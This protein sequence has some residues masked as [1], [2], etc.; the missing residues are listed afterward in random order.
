MSYRRGMSNSIQRG[1]GLAAG[2]ALFS[3]VVGAISGVTVGLWAATSKLGPVSRGIIH[4]LLLAVLV[5][6]IL[7]LVSEL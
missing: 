6:G 7:V 2:F 4:G 3:L 5:V 1:F